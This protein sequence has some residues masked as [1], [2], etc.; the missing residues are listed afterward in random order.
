MGLKSAAAGIL[1]DT[2]Q[3]RK[4][5]DERSEDFKADDNALRH[6]RLTGEC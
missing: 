6:G 2:V 3:K 5:K 1:A 4:F